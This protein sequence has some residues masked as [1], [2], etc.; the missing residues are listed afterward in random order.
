MTDDDRVYFERRAEQEIERARESSDPRIVAVHY[1]LS[2]LY[3]ERIG[4]APDEKRGALE[5]D[6][7]GH[8][9]ATD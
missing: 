2:E 4:A 8:S 3:L 1:A 7:E 6:G 5:Y 9:I